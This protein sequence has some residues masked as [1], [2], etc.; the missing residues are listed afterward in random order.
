MSARAV[1]LAVTRRRLPV[2]STTPPPPPPTDFIGSRGLS[3][4]PL[5]HPDD[6]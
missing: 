2:E 5:V 6:I 1:D 4:S 3:L